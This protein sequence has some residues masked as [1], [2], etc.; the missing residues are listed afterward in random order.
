[1][2]EILSK[3]WSPVTAIE[4]GGKVETTVWGRKYTAGK[5]SFLESIISQEIELLAEPIRVW[6]IENGKECVWGNVT[7]RILPESDEVTHICSSFQSESF[8]LNVTNTVEFDGFMDIGITIVPRGLPVEKI[9]GFG[10]E[11]R[12]YVLEKLS[13]FPP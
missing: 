12:D 7:H 9:G 2:N 5:K 11:D 6:G 10:T 4:K 8:I 3:I 1:M 13:D